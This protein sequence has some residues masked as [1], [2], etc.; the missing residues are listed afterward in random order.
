MALNRTDFQSLVD[1]HGPALYRLAYRLNGDA[2]DAEEIVQ[3]TFRSAWS[4]RDRF[5]STRGERAW[6]ASILRRRSADRWRQ[7]GRTLPATSG[8]HVLDY[9][10]EDDDPLEQ[11]YTDKMQAALGRLPDEMREALLMVIVGELT[12]QETADALGAPL[13]TILS[14]VSRGRQRLRDELLKIE[15]GEG[16]AA[17]SH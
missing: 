13:G 10:V 1:E 15:R 7:V 9:S 8:D 16:N 14:R 3:E 17:L 2:H 4:S 5:D 11:G 12:H 6:L